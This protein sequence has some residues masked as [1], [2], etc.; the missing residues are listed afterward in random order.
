MKRFGRFIFVFLTIL[1]VLANVNLLRPCSAATRLPGVA[2]GQFLHYS[3]NL[4]ISGNDTE[5]MAHAPRSQSGWGNITV[6]SV[7]NTNVTLQTVSYN[8]TTSQS[9]AII[10]NVETGQANSS[11]S[12]L[13]IAFIAANLSAGDPTYVNPMGAPPSINETVIADYLGMPLETNHLM[14]GH[15]ETNTYLYGYLVNTT[16][17]AQVYWERRTGIMLDYHIEQDLIRPDGVG[18]VLTAHLLFRE[19][20]LSVIPP[21]PDVPEFPSLLILP[22]FLTVTLLAVTIRKRKQR[23]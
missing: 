13:L 5:L 7:L 4:T 14:I 12:P 3:I 19:L 23:L 2:P 11:T 6:L 8:A 21:L 9:A 20:I 10:Q 1:L 15:S 16:L 17:T 22:L 18:G